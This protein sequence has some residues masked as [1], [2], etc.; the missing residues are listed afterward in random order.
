MMKKHLFMMLCMFI[1]CV[2]GT[3]GQA[4]FLTWGGYPKD[5]NLD[6]Y[7]KEMHDV[8]IYSTYPIIVLNF[9]CWYII[10]Q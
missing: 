1:M 2:Q 10:F 8:A 5:G 4:R 3:F 7:F 6:K 9:I